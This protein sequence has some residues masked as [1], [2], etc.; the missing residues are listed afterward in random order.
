LSLQRL[1]QLVS[2]ERLM[3]LMSL[4]RLMSSLLG[5]Q[6]KVQKKKKIG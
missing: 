2:L 3:Q 4:E 5:T 1:Q 6:R